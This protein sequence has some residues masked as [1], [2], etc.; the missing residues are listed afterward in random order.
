MSKE[1]LQQ[2]ADRLNHE[3]QSLQGRALISVNK[4]LVTQSSS[5]I[6]VVPLYMSILFK[7][8]AAE[9]TN[10]HCIE[11]MHRLFASG[12]LAG[13]AI[14]VDEKGRIRLDDLEMAPHLQQQIAEIWPQI[15]TDNIAELSAL[16]LYQQDFYHLFGFGFDNIDYTLDI[17]PD[18]SIPSLVHPD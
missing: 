17:D 5:A 15:D 14:A 7:L 4:A 1:H 9:G 12:W 6:P 16:D 10:E 13:T 2:T 11:Q 3:L 18:V 8:M